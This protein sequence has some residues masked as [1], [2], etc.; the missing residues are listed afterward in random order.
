VVVPGHARHGHEGRGAIPI[1]RLARVIV[2][3]GG[4]G[5]EACR[6][7]LARKAVQ[8]RSV[9]PSST[10]RPGTYHVAGELVRRGADLARICDEVYQSYPLSR[11]RLLRH[12]YSHFRLTHHNQIAYFWLKKADFAR[13]DYYDVWL[14]SL[15]PSAELVDEAL[16]APDDRAWTAFRRKF[17][18]EM[19]EPGP[20]RELDLL[21]ALSHQ[22][23]FSLGCY[24]QDVNRC[25]RS[26]LRELLEERGADLSVK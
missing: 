4:G 26:V 22:T 2:R 11:A 1:R 5:G 21:A 6:R 23:N 20:S 3:L 7:V 16:H 10:T 13:L 14:P 9:R 12:V 24:C 25:H 17:R 15:S 8:R 19:S 18:K